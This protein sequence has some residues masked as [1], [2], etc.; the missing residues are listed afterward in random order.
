MIFLP[1]KLDHSRPRRRDNVRLL[2]FVLLVVQASP[3][4]AMRYALPATAAVVSFCTRA[5]S[6]FL[7]TL[8]VMCSRHTLSSVSHAYD[9]LCVSFIS[10]GITKRSKRTKQKEG[11][12][13]GKEELGPQIAC[14]QR[15]V[16]FVRK[17]EGGCTSRR[18]RRRRTSL[19]SVPQCR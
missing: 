12:A 9:E 18:K 6:H 13:H 7:G 16:S 8:H 15:D 4:G 14:A 3:T 1:L 5:S 2:L 17:K 10:R 19:S 11:C